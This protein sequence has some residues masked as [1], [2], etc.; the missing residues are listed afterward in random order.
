[1][2]AK[3]SFEALPKL[4]VLIC[5]PYTVDYKREVLSPEQRRMSGHLEH[6][7]YLTIVFISVMDFR[8]SAI[9]F[10]VLFMLCCYLLKVGIAIDTITSSQSIKDPETL[11][12]KDG[13]FS[14]GFFSPE[15]STNRYVGIW[16]KSQ[17]TIIWV[18]NRNQP[19]NDSSGAVT[20]P[21]DGNLVVLNGERRIIWSSNV[22]HIV[23]NT[24]SKFSDFGK[25]VL[26]ESATGNILWDSFQQPSN[27]LLP[28][29][30]L[31]TNKT[32]GEKV[33]LK[34][35]KSPSNPSVGSFSVSV[36]A[37]LNI[38]QVFIW[39]GTRPYWRSGP[40]NGGVF[41]GI[42][43]MVNAYLS[44]QVGDDEEGN[45]DIYYTIS[46]AS[47]FVIYNLD[48]HGQYE[49]KWWDGEK[50]EMIV[51][52][53][54]RVS[55]CDVYGMC[56]PFASCNPLSSPI[57]SCL[58]GFEPSNT[59]EWN[60]QNWTSGCVRRTPLLCERVK[61]QNKSVDRKVDGFLKLQMIKLPDFPEGY[62]L[63]T[64]EVCGSQCLENCSCVAYSYDTSIGCMFW[65]GNLLDIQQLS[66]GGLDLYVRVAHTELDKGKIKTIIITITV[67]IGTIIIVTC[68]YV[69]WRRTSN[70][71]AKIWHSIKSARKQNNKALLNGETSDGYM[72]PEYAMQGLFSEKSD[73]FS[74]GV[75]VLEI[76]SGRRSSSFYDNEHA[77]SLLG[78]AWIQWRKGNILSLIDP[79]IYDPNHQKHI[80]RCIH[81][82]LLCVQELA[83]SRPIMA[84]VVPMLDSEIAFLPPPSQPAFI[85][86]ENMLNSMSYKES[87]GFC[88]ANTISI[89]DVHAML[90]MIALRAL[91]TYVSV[92]VPRSVRLACRASSCNLSAMLLRF[93]MVDVE[94]PINSASVI[95]N[96][97]WE[98]SGFLKDLLQEPQGLPLPPQRLKLKKGAAVVL[99]ARR[100]IH[101]VPIKLATGQWL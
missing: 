56:G 59:E 67:M 7:M 35:W 51:S 26:V 99:N 78:F 14:L 57:C 50:K 77:L 64:P 84:T 11:S 33:E 74:F 28:G 3:I 91:V 21:E 101:N 79:G 54:S 62:P 37:R 1:M 89:T 95:N 100:K 47:E 25:L 45:V 75:L 18:A 52:W 34:S 12:S 49:E 68:A 70:H 32:T 80:L 90:P 19:L 97:E 72:S 44:F 73:V 81:I 71:R 63:I 55:D 43:Q 76:I 24:S 2:K 58:K 8:H 41:I 48:S 87:D 46:S 27:T 65:T 30:K 94:N 82:G 13:N 4:E 31:L 5:K 36:V 93:T 88:S 9:L 16:W 20:I 83:A 85:L 23:S 39:N 40:W 22:S 86:R 29:M 98:L 38:P 6:I 61:D 15:N 96:L 53:S 69:M 42:S 10:F 66:S 17:S 92:S 60:M